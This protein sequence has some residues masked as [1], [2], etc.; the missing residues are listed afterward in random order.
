MQELTF[1]S[2]RLSGQPS[3][4]IRP[5]TAFTLVELLVVI[6]IIG[7]LVGLL[8]PAVQAARA[9]ARRVQCQNHLRQIGLGMHNYESTYRSL[10]WGA[11][12]GW[13]QSWTTDLLPFI[14]QTALW[15]RTPQG[16]EGW[17]TSNTPESQRLRELSQ[18]LVPT[19][20][21]PSQPGPD[22]LSEDGGLIESRAMNSYL[23]NAGSNIDRDTYSTSTY[24]GMEAGNGV[25]RVT[26]CVTNPSQAPWP[27]TIRFQGILDGL[28]HTVMISETR[29]I[30]LN[31]CGICDHFSLYHPDFDRGT[32]TDFSE[33][34]MSLKHGINL[35]DVPKEVLESSVGSFH[36]GG[37]HALMCD[38]SVQFM[39]DSLDASI[40]HAIGS[41]GNREVYDQSVWQ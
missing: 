3:R 15:D 7:I 39:T 4:R 10:P 22:Y 1:H 12:G 5:R 29:Y 24:L 38:G 21:C 35:Q 23:G 13:G 26:D 27:P 41:R 33:V 40:R 28:S 37:V 14:E 36:T 30:D 16:E 17:A 11:K 2:K 18:T 8:L 25:L 9:A 31:E 19:Y 34:L 20:R 6:A 32:G